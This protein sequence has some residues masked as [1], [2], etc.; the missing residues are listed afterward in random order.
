MPGPLHRTTRNHATLAGLLFLSFG[1]A[2]RVALGDRALVS[3]SSQTAAPGSSVVVPVVFQS[4]TA[5]IGGVQFDIQ[6][7]QSSMSLFANPGDAIKSSGKLF[8]Q[9]DVAPNTRRFLIVGLNS[10]VISTGTLFNLFV[11]LSPNA[12][13]GIFPVTVSNIAATDPTGVPT[14]VSSSDGTIT[15]AGTV[16][17]SVALQRDGVLNGA[18]LAPGPWHPGKIFALIGS[19]IGS[20]QVDTQVLFDGIP[21]SLFYVGTSQ[22]N[23]ITPNRFSGG[24]ETQMEVVAS[25]HAVSNLAVPVAA[26]SPAI[27]TLDGSGVGQG[28]I[29]NQDSTVNSPS[30]PALRGTIVALY[31]TGSGRMDLAGVEPITVRIGGVAA[32]VSYAGAA[33][34]WITG[35]VQVNCR[36]PGDVAPGYTVSIVLTAGPVS[37]TQSVTLAVQ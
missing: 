26:E 1:L 9:A 10:N 11:N 15:V 13:A 8:Y 30:N 7:D 28:A 29:L 20:N 12:S 2:P 18:S 23:G 27:F 34:G 36:V 19:N 4:S 31:A 33:P 24:S 32:E 3:F 35:L 6:Y 37:S 21:A 22:I 25:G 16:A 17:E 14:P 5:P